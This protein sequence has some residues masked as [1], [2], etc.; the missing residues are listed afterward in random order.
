MA[1]YG[2]QQG[3]NGLEIY[4]MCE[5]PANVVFADGHVDAIPIGKESLDRVYLIPPP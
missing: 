5:L 4:A 1:E 2:L 3:E